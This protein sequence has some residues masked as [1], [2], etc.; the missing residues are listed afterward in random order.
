MSVIEEKER[1]RVAKA[2]GRLWVRDI[3]WLS[4]GLWFEAVR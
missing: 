2:V 1:I 4:W 3:V